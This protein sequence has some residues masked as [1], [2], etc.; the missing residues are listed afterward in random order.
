MHSN[1]RGNSC[2]APEVDSLSIEAMTARDWP[3]VSKIYADGIA[4]GNATFETA[5]PQWEEWN[6]THLPACR[7]V[8][9]ATSEVLGW[10]ALSPVSRRRVYAGVAEVSLYVAQH[11]RRRNVGSRLLQALIKASE[12]EGVWTLQGSVFPENTAS[13]ELQKRHGFRIVGTREKIGCVEG[14]WRN[15]LLMERRSTTVGR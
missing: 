4:T 8:A 7:L 15:V 5:V 6:A 13:I 1:L 10:A 9:R 14:R 12:R 2:G 11:V 3:G